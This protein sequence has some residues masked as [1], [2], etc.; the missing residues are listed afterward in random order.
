MKINHKEL[1]AI[2]RS[3]LKD[4]NQGLR[5]NCPCEE[6]LID[7]ARSQLSP[8]RKRSVL[9]HVQECLDC[10][11]ELKAILGI[12]KEEKKFLKQISELAKNKETS[13]KQ[14][15]FF[16][17]FHA[18][19]KFISAA[20]VALL[21]VFTL[22]FSLYQVFHEH[23][24]RGSREPVIEI[25]EPKKKIRIYRNNIKFKWNDVPEAQYYRVVIFDSS[26][27]PIWESNKLTKN[28][29]KLSSELL[30]NMKDR[31]TYFL[32]VTGTQKRGIE[33]ESQLKE[34]KVIVKHPKN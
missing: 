28:S 15:S 26:L 5:K 34:F 19:R 24:Y 2:Y 33:I 23:K 4:K 32:L 17:P 22:T 13:K 16:L 3:S 8:S 27:F 31:A 9:N 30:E 14:K 20:A 1:K 29:V 18:S 7:L 6:D 11:E 10:S 25:T 21:L 12:L